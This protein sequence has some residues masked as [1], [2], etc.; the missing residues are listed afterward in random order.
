M[1]KSKSFS[2]W[3]P[4][5]TKLVWPVLIILAII[6]FNKQVS[7]IYSVVMKGMKEGRNVEIGGFLKLGEAASTTEISN[8]SSQE[9]SIESLGESG[10]GVVRKSGEVHLSRLK[11]DLAENPSKVINTLTI[12]NNIS[13]LSTNI[14]K[15]YISTLGLKYVVFLK[16]NKFDGWI[17]ASNLAA[18]LPEKDNIMKY[19]VLKD[20]YAGIKENK[21]LPSASAKEV[22]AKM[23]ELH[24]ESLPVVDED[25]NW[26]FF[27]NQ[28]EILSK[29]MTD[30]VLENEEKE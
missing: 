7:E 17:M 3:V 29:L 26:L 8:F 20:T 14:I 9:I 16:D 12:P 2:E 6:I 5:L 23:Q 21:V 27:V 10:S 19:G 4:L 18:Q 25:N 1:E 11:K 24:L 30:I 13:N 28:G 22:L 15:K